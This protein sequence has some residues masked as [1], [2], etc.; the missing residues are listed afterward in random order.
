MLS[1]LKYQLEYLIYGQNSDYRNLE[2]MT[3]TLLFWREASN[4][5][6]ML[7][8]SAK[9]SEA[10][11]VAGAL[12]AVLLVP[13]LKESAI[14]LIAKLER[15][16]IHDIMDRLHT[17]LA[18]SEEEAKTAK[19]G[20]DQKN[21]EDFMD[22][23]AFLFRDMLVYKATEN[24]DHLIFTDKLSYIRS[25]TVNISYEQLNE[26]IKTMEQAKNRIN[27]NVNI[28]LVL[29]LMLITIKGYIYDKSNRR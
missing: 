16:E 6:Y 24:P 28:D 18:P 26:I 22:I 25:V 9:Q 8:C 20:I 12:T 10:E 15:L 14:E 1:L 29:E 3:Q 5:A 13:E 19:K 17:M 7:G 23:L 2:K 4:F 21:F 11:L 27:S